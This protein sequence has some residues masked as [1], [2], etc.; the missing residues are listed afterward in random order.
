MF[1]SGANT[2]RSRSDIIDPYYRYISD[3]QPKRT[4]NEKELMAHRH[5]LRNLIVLTGGSGE[6]C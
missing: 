2:G 4:Y 1:A 5:V 6:N 3:T